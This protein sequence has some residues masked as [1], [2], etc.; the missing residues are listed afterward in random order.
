[1]TIDSGKNDNINDEFSFT[2][3]SLLMSNRENNFEYN[4]REE[5]E[6]V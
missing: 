2:K 3:N 4:S 5:E 6:K 1:M